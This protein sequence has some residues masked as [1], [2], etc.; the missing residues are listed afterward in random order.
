MIS[1]VTLYFHL[2][3]LKQNSTAAY[4][5]SRISTAPPPLPPQPT[6]KQRVFSG[7][8]T[9]LHENFGFIDEDVIFQNRYGM[10]K[11]VSFS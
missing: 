9:K 10:L 6:V 1:D 3:A 4:N 11:K 8:V 2:M 5:L 7:T